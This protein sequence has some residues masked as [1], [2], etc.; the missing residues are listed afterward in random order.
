M[1]GE[2]TA[3]AEQ[4]FREVLRWS[5]NNTTAAEKLAELGVKPD[6]KGLFGS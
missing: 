2:R 4:M 6:R 5:P 3:E 1:R